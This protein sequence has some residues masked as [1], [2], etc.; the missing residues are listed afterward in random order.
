M[1]AAFL[2]RGSKEWVW[3]PRISSDKAYLFILKK[4]GKK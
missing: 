3:Q 4:T 2:E 1:M